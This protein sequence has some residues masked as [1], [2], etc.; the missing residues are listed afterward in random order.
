MRNLVKRNPD[1]LDKRV[2]WHMLRLGDGPATR[3]QG[4]GPS[5]ARSRDGDDEPAESSVGRGRS[6]RPVG[7]AALMAPRRSRGTRRARPRATP[8]AA[9]R[10]WS[11]AAASTAI[12]SATAGSRLGPD[13]S[14]IGSR[15]TPDRLRQALVAPDEE[16]FPENRFVR[17]VTRDGATITGRLLN[18]DAISVQLINPKE[19]LKTYLRANLR[20]YTIVD[21][22]LMP[23]VRRQADRPAG[24]RHRHLSEFVEGNLKRLFQHP[25][26]LADWRPRA[27]TASG[28][29]SSIPDSSPAGQSWSTR[30]AAAPRGAS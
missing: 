20:E 11:R 7:W 17:F 23:S 9:R 5:R 30:R 25:A 27:P 13:L 8:R 19:E 22:G 10:W 29:S 26:R 24:G 21:K 15:R 4:S 1:L 14:D 6:V 3:R 12:A 28:S 2:R 16:V 18:Q